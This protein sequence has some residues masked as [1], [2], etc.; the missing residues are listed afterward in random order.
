MNTQ[1]LAVLQPTLGIGNRYCT[2]PSKK[3]MLTDSRYI[4]RINYLYSILRK[5]CNA[6]DYC[7]DISTDAD[8]ASNDSLYTDP[9]HPN[10]T[11]NKKI[12]DLMRERVIQELSHWH[13]LKLFSVHW[14]FCFSAT[15][16]RL[17]RFLPQYCLMTT[18]RYMTQSKMSFRSSERRFLKD[19]SSCRPSSTPCQN[20]E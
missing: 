10:S 16:E 6:R 3:C 15:S 1:Y 17:K 2:S 11:G 14:P 18:K 20:T 4:A 12:A 8:L 9:R 7:L 19:N 5:H 13:L